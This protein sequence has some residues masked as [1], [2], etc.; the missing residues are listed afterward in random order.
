M[1]RRAFAVSLVV[2]MVAFGFGVYARLD[3]MKTRSSVA[4]TPKSPPRTKPNFSLPGTMYLTQAGTIYRL[5]G[6]VFRQIATGNWTQPVLSPDHT[7]LVAVG[8]FADASDLYLL[9]LNGQVL[10]QL[11]HNGSRVVEDNHWSF[12][13]R[14]SPDGQ[15]IFYS[16][17]PKDPDNFYR[18]DL[19][20]FAMPA[21]GPQSR[22]KRWTFPWNYSGGDIQPV[23]LSSGALLYT[24]FDMNEQGQAFSQIW[25]SPRPGATGKALTR[26]DDDC[27]QPALSP[28]GATLA[29]ICTSGGQVG[30][31]AIASFDGMTVSQPHVLIDGQLSASPA[32]APDGSG[33]AYYAATGAAGHFQL[34]YLALPHSL[35][36]LTNPSLSPSPA[37]A[38][39]SASPSASARPTPTAAPL[40]PV[41]VSADL[42]FDPTGPPA[43]G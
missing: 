39:A 29:M 10:K 33:L 1:M 40:V 31:L 21:G 4:A 24:K 27:S 2:A 26:P 37:A 12:Y 22:A 19:A 5:Q 16:W 14:F 17:D 30:K 32:W 35:S 41:Q 42:D 7:Q 43:W 18:V 8:R 6:G 3:S 25:L 23:P 15:T 38:S 13:P 20:V 11:T 34:F 28:D 9:D 36:Q